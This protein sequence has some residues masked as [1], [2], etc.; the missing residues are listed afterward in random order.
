[1]FPFSNVKQVRRGYCHALL[2][3]KRCTENVGYASSTA[4]ELY[5]HNMHFSVYIAMQFSLIRCVL[6]RCHRAS[7]QFL[8]K[9]F[10]LVHTGVQLTMHT[11][12]QALHSHAYMQLTHETVGRRTFTVQS[13]FIACDLM[14]ILLAAIASFPIPW[15]PLVK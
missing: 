14:V 6:Q 12:G 7:I 13:G 9:Q 1:M 10:P 8:S 2:H 11:S 3:V 5:S 15:C 4:T